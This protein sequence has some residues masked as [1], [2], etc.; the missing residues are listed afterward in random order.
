MIQIE[1]LHAGFFHQNELQERSEN[2]GLYFTLFG[3]GF[4]E[5]LIEA[6]QPLDFKFTGITLSK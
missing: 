6:F 4:V 5:Q 2:F 3:P 1:K